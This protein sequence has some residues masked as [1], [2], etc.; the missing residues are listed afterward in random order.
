MFT[1][2]ILYSHIKNN[3]EGFFLIGFTSFCVKYEL[4]EIKGRENSF[5]VF[6]SDPYGEI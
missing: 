4:I 1:L 5:E 3:F 6:H 2:S